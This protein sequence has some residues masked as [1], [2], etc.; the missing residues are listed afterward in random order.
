MK[1]P[2][3]YW[4]NKERCQEEALKY[5]SRTEFKFNS[6]GAYEASLRN[7]WLDEVCWHMIKIGNRYNKCV[8]VYE[9][10]DNSVYVGITYDMK[11]RIRDRN[12]CKT[13]SVII[14]INETGLIPKLIQLTEY[15]PVDIAVELEYENVNKY[16]NNGWTILNKVKTG[17]I[18][19]V[20]KWTKEKCKDI[21]LKYENRTDFRKFANGTYQCAIFNNWIDEICLHMKELHKP[22]NYWTK[23]TCKLE[24]LKYNT[25]N[26]VKLNSITAYSVA[27]KNGWINE[28]SEHMTNGRKPNGYWTIKRCLEE[29]MKYVKRIDFQKNSG[30]AYNIAYSNGWLNDIYLKV[31]L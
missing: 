13:D 28:F 26:E 14:H 11:E 30:S 6:N 7:N 24:F 21:A 1:K 31:G 3:K 15:I 9:F 18:G 10:P 20:K 2:F 16:K 27:H 19:N 12:K 4:N 5:L 29:A 23:E 25:K 22:R 17:S 8:Y